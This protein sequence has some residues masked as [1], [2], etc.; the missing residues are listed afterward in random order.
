MTDIT[1]KSHFTSA[2]INTNSPGMFARLVENYR[3]RNINRLNRSAF[4]TL[5]YKDDR[6]LA[7]IGVTRAQVEYASKLPMEQNAAQ[8]LEK[9]KRLRKAA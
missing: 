4:R 8:E 3:Q 6:T 1:H 2:Q 7:D 5:L 9:M